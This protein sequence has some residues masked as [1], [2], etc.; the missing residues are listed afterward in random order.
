MFATGGNGIALHTQKSKLK[1]EFQ[2]VKLGFSRND[3][4]FEEPIAIL[5]G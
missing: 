3:N 4:R 2:L 5:T 1:Y